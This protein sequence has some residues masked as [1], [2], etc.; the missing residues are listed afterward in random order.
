M[1]QLLT[2]KWWMFVVRGLLALA[3]GVIAFAQ[4]HVALAA[5]VALF[6]IYAFIDGIVSLGGFFALTGAKGRWWLM[7]E[8]LFGIGAGIA[9]F[10]MPGVTALA[11]LVYLGAWLVVSGVMRVALAIELRRVIEGEWLLVLSGIFSVIA[12]VLTFVSPMQTAIAWMWLMGA[13]AIVAGV[14]L[15]GLGFRLHSLKGAGTFHAG[16]H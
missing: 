4:P 13:Y 7:V 2:D 12:G 6:G 5:L 11:L 3:F 14:M 15:L 16:A 10:V 8:A 1:F 9:T